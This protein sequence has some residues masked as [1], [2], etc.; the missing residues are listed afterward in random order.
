[1]DEALIDSKLSFPSQDEMDKLKN[2]EEMRS[3]N[4]ADSAHHHK[5]RSNIIKG[6][7]FCIYMF[8]YQISAEFV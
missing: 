6:D 2:F 3:I 1:M 5:Q 7:N 8:S 4:E